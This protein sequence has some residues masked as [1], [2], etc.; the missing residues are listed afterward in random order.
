MCLI[1]LCVPA[2]DASQDGGQRYVIIANRDESLARPAEPLHEWASGI[3]AG[4]DRL[5]GGT[6]IGVAPAARRIAMVTNVRDPADL[7]AAESNER[8]RG[9]LVTD[10][11]LGSSDA[12]AFVEAA[13]RY[14]DMRGFNLVAI[15]ARGAFW[16]SNRGGESSRLTPGVHGVSNALLDTPWPKVLRATAALR[17]QR[18]PLAPGSLFAILADEQRADDA[19]LPDTG[20]GLALERVLSPIRIV[21]PGYGTRC[22]TLVLVH[23]G[24]VTMIERT[25]APVPSGD[26]ILERPWG[27]GS[28]KAAS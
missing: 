9:A 4:R 21:A 1:A 11:L 2:D 25:L 24:T 7:R 13:R 26:V 3:L 15:D 14:G 17:A 18:A 27:G 10:Y 6:W 28:A 5:A 16:S 23:G 8:S 20:V 19:A 12:G 22:S